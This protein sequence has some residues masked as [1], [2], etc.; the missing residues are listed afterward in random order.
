VSFVHSGV[1]VTVA[2]CDEGLKPAITRGWGPE[3]SAD[4]RVLALL[5]AAPPGSPTREN[6]EGNGAIVVGFGLPTV[7]RAV[8]L[9]GVVDAVREPQS[10]ELERAEQHLR[11]FCAEAGQLGIPERLARRMF[12]QRSTLVSVTF[13]IEEAFDQTPGPTAGQRL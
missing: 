13:P 2:T 7:A 6:L 3:V 5:V 12:P 1:A 8:Q 9:K 10:A 4:A 11:S